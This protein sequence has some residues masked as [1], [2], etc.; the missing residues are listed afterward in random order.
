MEGCRLMTGERVRALIREITDVVAR[1]RPGWTAGADEDPGI[2]L[3]DLFGWLSD[4]LIEYQTDVASEEALE[5][6]RRL[7]IVR[8][9][10]LSEVSP[11]ITVDGVLWQPTASGTQSAGD[12][13]YVVETSPDGTATLRFGDGRVGGVPPADGSEVAVTYRSGAGGAR[14]TAALRWPPD[15]G[16]AIVRLD[17]HSV[18]FE[19]SRPRRCGLIARLIDCFRR[20][21]GP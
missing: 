5:T 1:Y 11:V 20:L 18:A 7:G 17:R 2:V 9:H 4:A 15:P 12:R 14:L 3:L 8:Y 19:P 10:V 13:T 6:L 16:A 21:T